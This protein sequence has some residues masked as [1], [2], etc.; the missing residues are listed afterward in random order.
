MED[1]KLVVFK[2]S[3]PEL[4]R[5]EKPYLDTELNLVEL[6]E[7]MGI[8]A[9]QLSYVINTGFNENFYYFVNKYG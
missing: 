6:A 8:S 2:D 9:H 4:M 1:S 5:E 3:L 7:L